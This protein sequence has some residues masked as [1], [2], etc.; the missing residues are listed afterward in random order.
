MKKNIFKISSI[1]ASLFP[2]G[3]LIK[4]SGIKVIYPFYHV[5]SENSPEHVKHLYIVK[6]INQFKKDLDFLVKHFKPI[7]YIPE[8][9]LQNNDPCFYLSFDDGLKESYDVI[10]PILK[11]YNIVA[12]Y[13]I[14]SAFVGNK[15]L[16]FKYKVSIL[17]EKLINGT[18]PSKILKDISFLLNSKKELSFKKI[19]KKLLTVSYKEKEVINKIAS[20]IDVDFI[21]YLKEEKPYLSKK[22]ISEM[23]SDGNIIGAHSIDHPLY[24]ELDSDSQIKQTADSL[25]YIA[26]EFGTNKKLFAFPF[27][28]DKVSLG[29]F[30]DIFR[31]KHA[32]YTFG[33]AGIKTDTVSR[34]IQR[35]PI[36]LHG[37]SAEKTIKTEYL[38][39]I[40][41]RMIRK[42]KIKR[43]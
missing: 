26:N 18:F 13:F 5:V 25:E 39:Y 32:D 43:R 1:F 24:S 27:T 31:K 21:A 38:L 28:D 10:S 3:L 37:L 41:K 6:A 19:F 8:D 9:P 14:N 34:S 12:T 23:I 33:T 11:E 30:N 29:F 17:I 16:F 7:N 4:L 2:I 20:I 35:I 15:D 22:Q 40:I 42:H 36:E